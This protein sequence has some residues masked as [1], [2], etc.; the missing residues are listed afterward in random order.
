MLCCAVLRCAAVNACF[1]SESNSES[2]PA[3]LPV[4]ALCA[5]ADVLQSNAPQG[6]LLLAARSGRLRGLRIPD[7]FLNVTALLMEQASLATGD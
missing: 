7:A 4:K 6:R 2:V 3:S 5:H 1:N